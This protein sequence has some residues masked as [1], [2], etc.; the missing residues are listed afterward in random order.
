MRRS[1]PARQ[2]LLV[3]VILLLCACS[4]GSGSGSGMEAGADRNQATTTLTWT[5]CGDGFECADLVVPRDHADASS[6]T[7][8]IPVIR[9]TATGPGERI[10]SLVVNPGGPG[11]AGVDYLRDEHE[12]LA[13]LGERYDL[14]S[15]DPR[16]AGASRP[17]V[18]CLSRDEIDAVRDQ[19]SA[20]SSP[21]EQRVA[22]DLAE[23][24]V[25]ACTDQ[26]SD[27]LPY[28]GTR[29]V[30]RDLDVLR[31]ALGD[32]RLTYLGFSYGTYL[33]ATYADMFPDHTE[34]MVLDGA[35]DPARDYDALRHD[36]AVAMDVA[37]RRFVTDCLGSSECPL[38]GGVDAGLAQLADIVA[39]LDEQPYEGPDGRTLS[40][41][42]ALA[43]IQSATYYPPETW[44]GLRDVLGAALRQD[45]QPMLER[46]HGPALMVNPA[47]T[48]YLAV[49]CHDLGADT[50]GG[51]TSELAALADEWAQD[52]PLNG[53]SRA[54]S[55]LPCRV[56]PERSSTPPAALAAEGSGP[57]L[58]VGTTHD[59]ATP[60]LWARALADELAESSLLEWNGDGHIA[61]GR[62]GACVADVVEGFLLEATDPPPTTTCP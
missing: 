8:T 45:Y 20:P 12:S 31:S 35:M 9:L 29:D 59:P 54:W 4:S 30:A 46:A 27:W 22:L 24:M 37:L 41:S 2:A 58:V 51:D 10:G 39:A 15:F 50:A 61:Y 43:L 32:A 33:G 38:S 42:R 5:P 6:P 21:E 23:S 13:T 34:R 11:I 26:V 40:G 49:M 19:V 3:S 52:A 44:E 62:A 7:F 47:D 56:W 18:D 16:G 28:V 60:F 53:P 17:A 55:T 1:T 14:V 48:P 25:Q 57:I 36:Q